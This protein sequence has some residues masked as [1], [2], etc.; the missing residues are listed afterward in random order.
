MLPGTLYLRP[1]HKTEN[2]RKVLRIKRDIQERPIFT[3]VEMFLHSRVG[4]YNLDFR[5]GISL[6]SLIF[7]PITTFDSH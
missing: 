5:F 1:V 7:Y 6:S 4:T 2:L 3:V